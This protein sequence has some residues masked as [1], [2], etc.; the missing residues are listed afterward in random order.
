VKLGKRDSDRLDGETPNDHVEKSVNGLWYI[1]QLATNTTERRFLAARGA[2]GHF[3]QGLLGLVGNAI[4]RFHMDYRK[5]NR[6][7]ER[8][9]HESHF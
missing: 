1:P 7:N 4:Y 5:V 3:Q 9:E 2:M 6:L 8:Q